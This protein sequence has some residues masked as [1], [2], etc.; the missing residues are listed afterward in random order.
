MA[1]VTHPRT[2]SMITI[3]RAGDALLEVNRWSG[4][5]KTSWLVAGAER[6]LSEGALYVATP[7]DPLFLL[8]PHLQGD[9]R[10]FQPLSNCISAE[11]EEIAA[12]ELTVLALPGLGKRL[13][14]VCDV[15]EGYDEPMVRLNE[16]KLLAWLRRKTEAVR[17]HLASDAELAKMAKQRQEAS[18]TSQF[19]GADDVPFGSVGGGGG[20]GGRSAVSGEDALLSHAVALVGE[21][22]APAAQSKLCAAL[23]V[24]EGRVSACRGEAKKQGAAAEAPS[25]TAAPSWASEG[26]SAASTQRGRDEPDPLPAAKK[27]KPAA[28]G[29]AKASKLGA[30]KKSQPTMMGFFS[31]PK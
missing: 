9:A 18:V 14:A 23:S 5:E 10:Y 31:K 7:L 12:M 24:E 1:R 6:V 27:P 28:P 11:P 17:A 8:L 21:Y 13:R 30:P 29:V 26:S 15:K 3:A 25:L 19:D 22:L 4:G 16:A 20:G 2:G